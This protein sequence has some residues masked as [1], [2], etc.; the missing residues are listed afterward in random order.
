M[1]F[2]LLSHEAAVRRLPHVIA[3]EPSAVDRMAALVDPEGNA[4]QR[5]AAYNLLIKS[6]LEKQKRIF[7]TWDNWMDVIG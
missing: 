6:E 3:K 7:E 4:A 1:K 2:A 5:V